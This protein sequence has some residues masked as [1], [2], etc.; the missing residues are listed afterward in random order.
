VPAPVKVSSDLGRQS[1]GGAKDIDLGRQSERLDVEDPVPVT[2]VDEFSFSGSP[3][4]L[5]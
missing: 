1:V 4:I 2:R 5:K 3:R